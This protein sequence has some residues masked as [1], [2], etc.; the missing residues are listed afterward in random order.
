MALLD[1]QGALFAGLLSPQGKILFEFFVVK[2]GS[3]FLLET[4]RDQVAGLIKRLTMYKLRAQVTVSEALSDVFVGAEPLG[5]G[6]FLDPRAAMLGQSLGQRLVVSSSDPI[7]ADS[8]AEAYHARRVGLCVPEA[9]NDYAL[10]DT[11]PHEANWD[12]MGGVSFKKGCFIGQEVVSRMQNK[13]VVR[14]RIVKVSGT[15]ALKSGVDVMLG[16]AVIGRVGTVAGYDALAM[17][18]LDRVAEVDGAGLMAGGVTLT[19]DADALQ[20]YRE[21]VAS[22]PVIDL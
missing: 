20:R 6:E 18:R 1:K 8:G 21:S 15:E 7:L 9:P 13:T 5:A 14:K 11:F 19:V 10:G 12:L 16:E 17:L 2:S 3:G 4:Q 22:K